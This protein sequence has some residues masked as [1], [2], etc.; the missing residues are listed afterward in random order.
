[1]PSSLAI[2]SGANTISS[3]KPVIMV[4]IMVRDAQTPEQGVLGNED[5]I[6]I[7]NNLK[8]RIFKS[9]TNGVMRM[10]MYERVKN[11]MNIITGC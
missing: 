1:M 4:I 11:I 5:K 10:R 6:Q 7:D 8:V 9:L 3:R 2:F